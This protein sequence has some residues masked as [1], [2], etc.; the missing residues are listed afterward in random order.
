MAVLNQLFFELMPYN[1]AIDRASRYVEHAQKLQPNVEQVLVA[2][3]F[4]LDWQQDGLDYKRARRELETAANRLI[5]YYPNNPTGYTELGVLRRNTGRY[6][7]CADLWMKAIQLIPRAA[8]IKNMYWNVAYCNV[9]AGHD[10]E[11]LEWADRALAATGSLPSYRVRSMLEFR[12]V[13][14]YR[15]GDVDT[16]RRLATEL[17][18]QFPFNTWRMHFPDDPESDVNRE[19]IRSVQRA[20]KAAGNRDHLDPEADFGVSPDN[21]LHEYMI[22]KTPTAAPGV[23]TVST[24]QLS[25][26]L[27]NTEPLVIDTMSNSWDRSVPGAVG[28]DFRGNTHGTFD[29]TIQRRLETKVR[30]LTDGNMGKPI[31]AMS[32]NVAFFDSYNLALRLRHMGYRNVFWYR[33]GREAWE[34]AGKTEEAVKP[35]DW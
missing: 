9:C 8:F 2:Q 34:V 23:T 19:Q 25:E 31:V 18:E 35:A 10:K 15:S 6:P 29:D 16:G 20:L 1:V 3:A 22:G 13:A 30:E 5:E 21:V 14:A 4:L 28:L 26:M 7:E 11:G 32:F 12:S 27:E 24:E 17:N 33:G